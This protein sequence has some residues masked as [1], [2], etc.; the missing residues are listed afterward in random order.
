MIIYC[1][2]KYGFHRHIIKKDLYL[3]PLKLTCIEGSFNSKYLKVT[4]TQFFLYII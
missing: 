3:T 4:L 2:Y 1:T